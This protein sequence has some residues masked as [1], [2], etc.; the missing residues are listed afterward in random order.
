MIALLRRLVRAQLA[1][2]PSLPHD[3]D[4]VAHAEDLRQLGR[5]HQDRD[6]VRGELVHQG[7]DFRLRA[8]VD[9]ARRLVHDQDLR[10]QRQP[11][12]DDHL[13]LV[14]AGEIEHLLLDRRRAHPQRLDEVL[15][16][17]ARS[18]PRR[19]TPSRLSRSR[20]ER[21]MFSRIASL[22]TSACS[23][24]SSGTRPMPSRIAPRGERMRTGCPS[25]RISPRSNASAPK[26]GARD[27]GPAR[28][29]QPRQPDD[30]AR[31][32]AER[33]VFEHDRRGVACR[34]GAAESA[35]LQDRRRI[36]L[37]QRLE[38]AFCLFWPEEIAERPADHQPHK[39]VRRHL[40]RSAD[41]RRAGRRAA[42]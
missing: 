9:P 15:R 41:R 25:T 14:A 19:T 13:L 30:L 40:G 28:A 24:R 23:L 11:L 22:S 36:A 10:V 39:P 42:R 34:A 7:V 27:L 29:D 37:G 26:I 3:Q 5:D 12:G 18:A 2:D 1:G 17:I 35:H 8:D 21:L 38:P 32:Q 6:A 31:P 33:D 20:I 16:A 4:A